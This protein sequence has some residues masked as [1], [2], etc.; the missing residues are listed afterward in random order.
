MTIASTS[1][2][3]LPGDK[4]ERPPSH[5]IPNSRTIERWRD[6]H[7]IPIPAGYVYLKFYK[8]SELQ[9]NLFPGLLVPFP[10]NVAPPKLRNQ[11]NQFE[12]A[13]KLKEFIGE[14]IDRA[15]FSSTLSISPPSIY[16][17]L[18][19]NPDGKPK[20][21]NTLLVAQ[22]AYVKFNNDDFAPQ[23]VNFAFLAT[24]QRSKKSDAPGTDPSALIG[25]QT[26]QKSL[27]KFGG[28]TYMRL[29]RLGQFN[30]Y[31]FSLFSAEEQISANH[32]DLKGKPIP[33]VVKIGHRQ[34]SP[35]QFASMTGEIAGLIRTFE[36]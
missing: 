14:E 36:S 16:S 15:F 9:P 7:R 23:E 22:K 20:K 33:L 30:K 6:K 10:N 18:M 25:V 35:G 29:T 3:Q 17:I 11:H 28:S 4:Y 19:I 21:T 31:Q 2:A 26:E 27:K 12:L 5:E 8:N 1:I 24:F 34:I 32:F 13:A